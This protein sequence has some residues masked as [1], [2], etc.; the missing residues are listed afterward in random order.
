MFDVENKEIYEDETFTPEVNYTE[1]GNEESGM[2]KLIK[3]GVGLAV[4]AAVGAAGWIGAKLFKKHKED[5]ALRRP[6]PKEEE[7]EEEE[8]AT[9]EDFEEETNEE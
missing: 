2:S 9:E 7:P 8:A 4:G 6:E 1:E 5:T 3:L